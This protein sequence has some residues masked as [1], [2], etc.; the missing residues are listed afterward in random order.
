MEGHLTH[1]DRCRA[2]PRGGQGKDFSR[3]AMPVA[4]VRSASPA[5]PPHAAFIR[6]SRI[7]KCVATVSDAPLAG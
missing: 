2:T 5:R 7:L 6:T 1:A 3:R 4:Q